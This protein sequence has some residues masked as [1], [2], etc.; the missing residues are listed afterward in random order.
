MASTT[1][2]G[3]T[4]KPGAEP[5]TGGAEP[6]QDDDE[7]PADPGEVEGSEAGARLDDFDEE[8]PSLD[9]DN[10]A[11]LS[12]DAGAGARFLSPAKQLQFRAKWNR[13]QAARARAEEAAMKKAGQEAKKELI[14]MRY[15]VEGSPPFSGDEVVA[16]RDLLSP[17]D[18]EKWLKDAREGTPPP[19][20]SNPETL[21]TLYRMA[22]NGDPGL[23]DFADEELRA[24]R[25][26][27]P[28]HRAALNEGQQFRDPAIK[29]G[30]EE[31][32]LKTGYSEM[33]P[34]PDAA[35]SFIQAKKDFIGWLDSPAGK[36]ADDD[37][38]LKMAG[39][40]ADNYRLV[41]TE[42]LLTA[43]APLFL[44]GSRTAPDI[45]KTLEATRAALEAGG[46]T[47]EEFAEQALRIKRLADILTQQQAAA[48]AAGAKQNGGRR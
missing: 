6:I 4:V 37:G 2:S 12:D 33:N 15:G 5:G 3:P 22:V 47:E 41:Q 29:R 11:D 18:Y 44:V 25:L 28:D 34:N 23:N 42:S 8:M 7:A 13:A 32:R 26:T 10:Y 40:I 21:I 36:K 48:E 43:P 39:R 20:H 27:A 19:A 14:D 1:A 17:G 9:Q 16:R 45:Q 24:A 38:K 35:S 31:I 46:L 30:L